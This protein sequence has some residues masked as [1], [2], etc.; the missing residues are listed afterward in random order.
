M[1]VFDLLWIPDDD[2]NNHV[3]SM[4]ASERYEFLRTK[5]APSFTEWN[6]TTLALQWAGQYAY[7]KS[8]IHRNSMQCP[9]TIDGVILPGGEQPWCP[10]LEKTTNTRV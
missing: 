4:G 9:H 5:I 1:L 7:C 10:T 6:G 3:A 8:A 2:G